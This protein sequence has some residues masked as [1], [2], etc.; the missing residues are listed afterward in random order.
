[1]HFIVLGAGAIGCYVG[2]RLAAHG[3]SVCLVGRPHALEPIALNGLKVTDLDGF[4][5]PAPATALQLAYSLADAAPGRDSIIL[6]C[7]K[8]GATESAARELAA[9]CAPGTPVISLQNGV[10]NVARVTAVAPG[11]NVLAGMVPYNVVLRGAHVHRAT[12]GH[13]QLQRDAATERVA[14]IFNAAGLATVLP[15]DIRAV[16]WGKLLLNLNNPVNALSDLPLRQELLDR[17]YRRVFAAL[18]TEALRVMARAGIT[19][20]QV[21]AVSTTLLPHVLRLPNWLFTRLAQRMLQIDATARS[22]MWDDL[23]AGRVTEVDALSGAVVRLAEKHGMQA[24]L[25]ARM[26]ELLGG[27]RQRLTG[28]QM[29]KAL[30]L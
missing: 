13:L 19:P 4:D 22:S 10:D 24:P 29:R 7:V 20:A 23:E 8:S 2:G 11:L 27:P 14:P 9:A 6:L 16:Q 28:A 18:Q 12:A 5:H 1:M 30:G 21:T 3:H 26:C 25:N 17:D 15:A